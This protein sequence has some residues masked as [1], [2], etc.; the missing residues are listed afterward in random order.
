LLSDLK[1]AEVHKAHFGVFNT[2]TWSLTQ[3]GKTG[4]I[5]ACY[6]QKFGAVL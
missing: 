6:C 2:L 1:H 5:S 4:N 3:Q